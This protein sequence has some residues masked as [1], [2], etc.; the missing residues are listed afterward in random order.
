MYSARR[1]LPVSS[2][3]CATA[4]LGYDIDG[5]GRTDV[6]AG[7]Q[8]IRRPVERQPVQRDNP[9]P[10]FFFIAGEYWSTL[11]T[12]QKFRRFFAAREIFLRS[13]WFTKGFDTR[14]LREAK[15]LLEELVA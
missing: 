9:A 11:I 10:S 8:I 3:F 2:F 12:G 7:L 15:A 13:S 1:G 4:L 5:I 6:E 14:D